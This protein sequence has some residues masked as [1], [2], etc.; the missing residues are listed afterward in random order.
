[1]YEGPGVAFMPQGLKETMIIRPWVYH[2]TEKPCH[3]NKCTTHTL[4]KYN[5]T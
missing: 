2:S 5:G 3:S 1:M 4:H